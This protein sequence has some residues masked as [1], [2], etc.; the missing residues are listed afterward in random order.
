MLFRSETNVYIDL[1]IVSDGSYYDF[2][3]SFDS[4]E[5]WEWIAKHVSAFL[6]SSRSAGGFTGTTLGL[7]ATSN[8]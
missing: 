1:K 2:Y 7:Y 5:N 3:Y 8:K 4:G 6:T